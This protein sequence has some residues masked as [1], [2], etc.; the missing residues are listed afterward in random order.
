M[1]KLPL[2]LSDFSNSNEADEWVVVNDGV[3]GGKSEGKI[4]TNGKTATFKGNVSLKNN[5]GFTSIR[6]RFE[7]MNISGAKYLFIELKGD[8]KDYQFR[9]KNSIDERH[10]FKYA[11]ST[12]GEWETVPIQLNEM[13]PTYRGMRPNVP[14]YEANALSEIGFLIANKKAEQFELQI[15][16][17]WLE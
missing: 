5:G 9:L 15:A 17:I 10:S 11:F 3:M 7:T 6:K 1:L 4:S 13:T 8:K 12:S 14:N 2:V 16:K